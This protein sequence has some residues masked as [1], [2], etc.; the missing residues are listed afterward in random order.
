MHVA[1]NK[2]EGYLQPATTIIDNETLYS[3]GF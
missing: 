2:I 3:K 1:E